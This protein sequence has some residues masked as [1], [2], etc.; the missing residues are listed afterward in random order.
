VTSK[1]KFRPA[2][3]EIEIPSTVLL[4]PHC[5]EQRHFIDNEKSIFSEGEGVWAILTCDRCEEPILAIYK[6]TRVYAGETPT[7]EPTPIKTY[8]PEGISQIHRSIPQG[9]SEDYKESLVCFN[10]GAWKATVVLCRR[11]L[12]SSVVEKRADVNEK[13]MCQIDELTSKQIIT[14][15]IKDWNI[16]MLERKGKL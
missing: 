13:L 16:Y 5:R 9:I 11:A 8:P 2:R 10:A 15:D 6:W 1:A 7:L 3:I 4:C 12:Q 14:E